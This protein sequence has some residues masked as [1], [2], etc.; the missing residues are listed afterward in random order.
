MSLGRHER[1]LQLLSL[2]LFLSLSHFRFEHFNLLQLLLT[3]LW[4]SPVTA[5][6]N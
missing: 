6:V 2:S 5:L 3:G 4:V 1:Q